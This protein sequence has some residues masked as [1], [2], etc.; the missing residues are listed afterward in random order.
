MNTEYTNN[1]IITGDY[2]FN[3][4]HFNALI[5]CTLL[6]FERYVDNIRSETTYS[7]NISI[8]QLDDKNQL[9]RINGTP[10]CGYD[11]KRG[12]MYGF[13]F[14]NASKMSKEESEKLVSIFEKYSKEEINDALNELSREDVLPTERI[15]DIISDKE[16]VIE[17]IASLEGYAIRF[18]EFHWNASG[19]SSHETAERAYDLVY[20]LEDSIAEDVMGWTGSKI[21]PG[22]INPVFP[23][24]AD[25]YSGS[26]LTI[27]EVLNML[28]NDVFSF[29]VK[30]EH[31]NNFIGIRSELENFLHEINQLVYLAKLL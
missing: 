23:V 17:F 4:Y 6:D 5:E 12:N 15:N 27:D 18:K 29:Y 10:C 22:S 20:T 28:K 3:G 13:V 25:T 11:Q 9:L 26:A 30:I 7:A 8:E 21:K 31:N 14:S 2:I 24:K 19:K 1:Q 16:L